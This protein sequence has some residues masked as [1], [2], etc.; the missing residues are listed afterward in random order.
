MFCLIG[1]TDLLRGQQIYTVRFQK[2]IVFNGDLKYHLHQ[3]FLP[4]TIKNRQR[5]LDIRYYPSEP[6]II[7]NTENSHYE[8]RFD[9]EKAN[10][11]HKIVIEFDIEL[12]NYD[13]AEARFIKQGIEDTLA[14]SK[15]LK[16]E[17]FEKKN[18][19]L[20]QQAAEK[21]DCQTDIDC[22]NS[23]FSFV[24]DHLT[25]DNKI[26]ENIGAVRALK[27]GKG[28]CTEYSDLMVSLCR[29]KGIPA[30][31]VGGMYLRTGS[32]IYHN[33]VE[34]YLSEIGWVPFDPTFGDDGNH[35][36]NFENLKNRYVYIYTGR[37]DAKLGSSFERYAYQSLTSNTKFNTNTS[38]TLNIDYQ[39]I[40]NEAVKYY[41]NHCYDSAL[42]ILNDLIEMDV[43]NTNYLT[44]KAMLLA[45]QGNFKVSQKVFQIALAI[46]EHAQQKR[47]LYYG[48]SNFHAL[49]GNLNYS[50]SFLRASMELGFRS[51]DQMISDEDLHSIQ[52]TPEFLQLLRDYGYDP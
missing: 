4:K 35:D 43:K 23:I 24:T 8:F 47:D 12:F 37:T 27:L 42:V 20:I 36:K 13:L 17:S 30:R 11:T 15:Y 50:L 29:A 39:T 2:D 22:T 1:K 33:W 3:G 6:K 16:S 19:K 40:F 34:V 44:F 26:L 14:I 45:R 28:D 25:Y 51:Y 21:I 32:N 41:N 18:H 52:D 49:S 48:Y 38:F 10:L 31:V 46:A 5:V 9:D 7:N